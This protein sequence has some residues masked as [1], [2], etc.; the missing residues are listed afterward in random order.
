[1]A[2]QRRPV[3][4]EVAV[5]EVVAVDQHDVRALGASDHVGRPAS[6]LTQR[7]VRPPVRAA[8]GIAAQ[9]GE[10]PLPRCRSRRQ[11]VGERR[12][13]SVASL[14]VGDRLGDA[15]HG[16]DGEGV[17]RVRLAEGG[18][19]VPRVHDR[20]EE[21][22]LDEH[23]D[24]ERMRRVQF[25][26]DRLG[27]EV[28]RGEGVDE[29][30]HRRLP[31]RRGER[32]RAVR[33]GVGGAGAHDLGEPGVLADHVL[34]ELAEVPLGA[35]RRP[36]QVGVVDAGDVAR[37]GGERRSVELDGACGHGDQLITRL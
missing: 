2:L 33:A 34:E 5:A 15:Q 36:G 18:G 35:W 17:W 25:H 8:S 30:I 32:Q 19:D 12:A 7:T 1:M 37:C 11:G 24:R 4:A 27:G 23:G 14:V 20:V 9:Q 13:R 29:I 3:A 26:R 6:S 10:R 28:A 21:L 31:R 16:V 22:G